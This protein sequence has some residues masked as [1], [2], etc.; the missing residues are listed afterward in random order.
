MFTIRAGPGPLALFGA[1]E[2]VVNQTST[3]QLIRTKHNINDPEFA[4][5]VVQSFQALHG[6]PR[7]RAAGGG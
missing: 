5:L 6:S 7:V 4:A 1:L 2:Q 3:R